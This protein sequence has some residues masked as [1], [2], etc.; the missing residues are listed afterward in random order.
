MHEQ[1]ITWL[2]KP[3]TKLQEARQKYDV[4]VKKVFGTKHEKYEFLLNCLYVVDKT[5]DFYAVYL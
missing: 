3:R 5:K 1:F 4:N 2:L